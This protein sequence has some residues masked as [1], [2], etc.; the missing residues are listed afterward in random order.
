M[1]SKLDKEAHGSV[2]TEVEAERIGRTAAESDSINIDGT[3]WIQPTTTAGIERT[4]KPTR[5]VTA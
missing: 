4:T 2:E 1:T 5:S 3:V